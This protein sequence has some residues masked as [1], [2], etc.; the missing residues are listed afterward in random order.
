MALLESC[1]EIGAAPPDELLA[2]IARQLDVDGRSRNAPRLKIEQMT[3]SLAL[4]HEP[5]ISEKKLARLCGVSRP[6]VA[7][8]KKDPSFQR[9]KAIFEMDSVLKEALPS[10]QKPSR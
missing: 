2:I 8:W 9:L 10:Q 6:T 7:R 1:Q 5:T 4:A 3:A